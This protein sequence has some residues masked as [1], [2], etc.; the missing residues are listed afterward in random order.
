MLLFADGFETFDNTDLK[1]KW[2]Y[3]TGLDNPPSWDD[4]YIK[5][6][7]GVDET[8]DP[9]QCVARKGGRALQIARTNS[10]GMATP[11]KKSRTVFVGFALRSAGLNSAYNNSRS[12][13]AGFRIKFFTRN[14]PYK[15]EPGFNFG[16]SF[17]V[18]EC[19]LAFHTTSVFCTWEFPDS[20]IP[21]QVSVI[22]TL[23]NPLGGD[24]VYYQVGM[25]LN[26]NTPNDADKF[27]WVENRIGTRE[28]KVRRENILTAI[29][30]DDNSH[31]VNMVS[32][33]CEAID[34]PDQDIVQLDDVYICNDE[35]PV[36][37]TFLG[38]VRI[39]R[40]TPVIQGSINNGESFNF[41]G[42]R[43][44]GVEADKVNTVDRLPNPLPDPEQEPGFIPWIDPRDKY[45]RLNEDGVQLFGLTHPN[46]AG[47]KPKIHGCVATVMNR[48]VSDIGTHANIKISRKRGSGLVEVPEDE[49]SIMPVNKS[50]G[51]ETRSLAF[52][53]N[54]VLPI[55]KESDVWSTAAV[56]NTEWGIQIKPWTKPP[57]DYLPG[58]LRHN[59]IYK[60]TLYEIL[61]IIPFV[62]RFW[63]R[64]VNEEIVFVDVSDNSWA[65]FAYDTLA[66]M[67]DLTITKRGH[68]GIDERLYVKD[69]IPWQYL[70]LKEIMKVS[71][72]L[73]FA[74]AGDIAEVL[75]V[76]DDSID[77]WVEELSD[78][79]HIY[80]A[81]VRTDT[82]ENINE[83]LALLEPL[84]W[85]NHET[86]EDSLDARV[87]HVWSAHALVEEYLWYQ[88][89]SIAAYGQKV[90]E[91][92]GF[93]ENHFDGWWVEECREELSAWFTGIT[94]QWRYEW[95]MGV[96]INSI[97]IEPIED[98]GQWGGTGMD[99][100]RTGYVDWN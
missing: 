16:P 67:V 86:L 74:W 11:I 59:L 27:A 29:H 58:H 42:S 43:H 76:T 50:G 39:K 18:A 7:S 26:G 77:K 78:T 49:S 23:Q 85:D 41:T 31:Y 8:K 100:D 71:D 60:D 66:T 72:E 52:D 90:E 70:F 24:F 87:T 46:Y 80:G 88:E 1:R 96:I 64:M 92:I 69:E 55:G 81:K 94:Q 3:T 22:D 83:I 98:T 32:L 21:N 53:N 75:G 62:H 45:L 28:N 12:H 9:P 5:I 79:Y 65:T 44:Y 99:G 40:M 73:L 25:T 54:E 68:K 17:L 37:N 14:L 36:N 89:Y 2:G 97:R 91:T 56:D 20:R 93:I 82:G 6:V 57:E 38:D 47:A 4:E 10:W 19:R 15:D 48:A 95:F 84:L 13:L 63:D 34:Y 35:G 61:G 51:W 33:E 30:G